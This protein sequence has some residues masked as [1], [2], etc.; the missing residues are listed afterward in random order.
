MIKNRLKIAFIN[1]RK[2]LL[3]TIINIL[4]LSVGLCVF[5]LVFIHWQDEKS[6]E[7]H[8]KNKDLIFL[9][10]NETGDFGKMVVSGYPALAVSKEK[11]P[12]IEDF[13]IANF[14]DI[15]KV[16]LNAGKRSAYVAS[17][18]ASQSYFDFFPLEKIAGTF[19]NAISDSQKMA[20]SEQTAKTLFGDEYKECIGRTVKI[21]DSEGKNYIITAVYR[22]PSENSIFKPDFIMKHPDIGKKDLS[23]TNYSYVGYFKIKPGT[24]IENLEKKLSD[25]MVL[26]EKIAA[27]SW[28]EKYDN[29]KKARV[30]LT[31]ISKMKLDARSEGI[32]KGDKKSIM[33]LLGLSSLILLLSGINLINLKTAQ[34]SQRAKEVGIR[35]VMGSTRSGLVLQFLL[36]TFILCAAAYL[37]AFAMVELLLPGYNTFLGKEINLN[38]PE[39]FI[40]SGLLLA[41]FS[42]VSGLIPALYLSDFKPVNTLKGNFAR[43]RSGALLRNF[44]LTLQLIISSFFIICSLII[45]TQVSYMMNKDLGFKGDQVIYIPFKKIDWKNDFNYK[46]YVLLK[47]EISKMPGVEEVT[48]S[49][50]AIGMGIANSSTVRNAADTTKSVQ[51]VIL[52]AIDYNYFSFY[53]MK[54]ASG[55]NINLRL[56]SDTASGAIANEA[57]IRKMGWNKEQ[58]LGKEVFP[59][60]EQ[61][62]KYKILGVIKDFY[63]NGVDKPIEPILFFNYDRNWSKN[64][65]GNIQIKLLGNDINGTLERIKEFWTTKGEPGYPYD[66]EFVDKQFAKTFEKFQKQQTLFTTL[67]MV[68]LSIALLGLF[69]L[70]SLLIGQKLKDVAIRKTLGAD[71]K[72]IVWDL[73][74]RFLLICMI[75][76]LISI[77][78][79]YYAMNEWLKD[80]AYRIDMPVWP[81]VLSMLLLLV[82]TFLVVSFKAWY[83]TRI[84]P[85]QYLKYE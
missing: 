84:N 42:L 73:T 49:V 53:Q 27:E 25:Q 38:N 77:P 34:A 9:V 43:S 35:K 36:E 1:Y 19:R 56:A 6:Y 75:A 59:G 8:N 55:R 32:K 76:V 4:G 26:Q 20:I 80:F 61:K 28:G 50:N 82:L 11:F 30:F 70:S 78:F 16:K 33:I 62:K 31:P 40:Y 24:D 66:F 48:G 46:K 51:N 5:L 39:I 52:G 83:A 22:V 63:M 23:W 2:N 41:V 21:D 64:N 79:A 18:R 69:A 58:A 57:F 72:T 68:V 29:K 81:Y 10:E 44:I 3:S 7:Q 17:C 14:W 13:A 12:E 74:K 54:F 85:I 60:W 15:Y 37:L 47:S 67:N 65:M 45:H 71:R